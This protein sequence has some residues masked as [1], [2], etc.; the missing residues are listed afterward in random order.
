M[1]QEPSGGSQTH[2]E[3]S[4]GFNAADTTPSNVSE[5]LTRAQLDNARNVYKLID[6]GKAESVVGWSYDLHRLKLPIDLLEA[7]ELSDD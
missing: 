3:L 7:V 5:L 6:D 2:P 1:T 4:S